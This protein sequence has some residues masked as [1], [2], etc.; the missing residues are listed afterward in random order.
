MVDERPRP[1]RRSTRRRRLWTRAAPLGAV[2]VLS[3]AAGVLTGTAPGRAERHL[4]QQYVRAWAQAD[5][6]KMYSLLDSRS[7]AATSRTQFEATYRAAAATATLRSVAPVHVGNRRGD[8][9]PVQMR[10]RTRVFGTLNETLQVPLAGSGSGASVK[11]SGALVF[12]GLKP[13]EQLTRRVTLASRGDL[14]ASDGT[15]LAQGPGRT[16]PIPDVASQI[17]GTLGPIPPVTQVRIRRLDIQ[18]MRRSA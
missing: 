8:E 1:Q 5:F 14:L 6:A 17:V 3:F 4:V 10:V 16:S 9:I 12:P 18:P 11:F 13:G 2:A 15:P 7:R